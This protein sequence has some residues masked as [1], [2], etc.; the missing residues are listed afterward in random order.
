MENTQILVWLFINYDFS[1]EEKRKYT[2]FKTKPIEP[3]KTYEPWKS[4]FCL[5][6]LLMLFIMLNLCS[7]QPLQCHGYIYDLLHVAYHTSTCSMFYIFK[8][9]C[10]CICSVYLFFLFYCELDFK[11]QNTLSLIT[12]EKVWMD[13]AVH[14]TSLSSCFICSFAF[15]FQIHSLI[16]IQRSHPVNHL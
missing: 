9:I 14:F 15:W 2:V 11:N 8:I 4:Y 6:P 16:K 1:E 13:S 5:S 7:I 12:Q 10:L 3:R